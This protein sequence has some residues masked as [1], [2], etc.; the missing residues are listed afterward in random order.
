MKYLRF[1]LIVI[2]VSSIIFSTYYFIDVLPRKA[3]KSHL[4][5]EIINLQ[6]EKVACCLE[7]RKITNFEWDKLFV[8]LP[9]TVPSYIEDELG[10]KWDNASKVTRRS[11]D[12]L[13]LL[14]FVKGNRVVEYIEFQKGNYLLLD[15]YHH[16]EFTPDEAFFEVV[17]LR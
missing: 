10:F 11:R 15:P 12:G 3:L 1:I 5:S 7:M 14:I 2:V 13:Y 16:S 17:P 6:Q 9:Y 4:T 8:F